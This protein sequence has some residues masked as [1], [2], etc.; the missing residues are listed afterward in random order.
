MYYNIVSGRKYE[1]K[2]MSNSYGKLLIHSTTSQINNFV[3]TQYKI[4]SILC[5]NLDN[6]HLHP[7]WQ[8]MLIACMIYNCGVLN[9]LT[10]FTDQLHGSKEFAFHLIKAERYEGYGLLKL[11]QMLNSQP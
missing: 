11:H 1:E 6:I 7:G 9:F 3:L 2:K 4:L 8:I 5:T 10:E